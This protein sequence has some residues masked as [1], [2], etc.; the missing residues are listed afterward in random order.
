MAA[1]RG[2]WQVGSVP[3]SV[4]L[5]PAP[6]LFTALIFVLQIAVSI[7]N[8]LKEMLTIITF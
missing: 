8:A 7:L 3:L 4:P 5:L 2:Y 1:V 6:V